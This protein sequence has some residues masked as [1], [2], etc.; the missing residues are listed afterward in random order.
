MAQGSGC[1]C[2]SHTR[3]TD[4]QNAPKKKKSIKGTG[5]HTNH[6]SLSSEEKKKRKLYAKTDFTAGV[7]STD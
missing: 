5:M 4:N 7:V 3:L 1:H 2:Q 6:V